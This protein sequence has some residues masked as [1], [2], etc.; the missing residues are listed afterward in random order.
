M[1]LVRTDDSHADGVY[2]TVFFVDGVAVKVFKRREDAAPDHVRNVFKSEVTAYCYSAT[3]ANIC[4]FTKHFIGV[5]E[6]CR[7]KDKDGL[8]ISQQY[9]LN[10]AYEM[11]RLIGEPIKIGDLDQE[12]SQ[13]I[14][15]L[16][17]Q[18]G[19]WYVRDCSVFLNL[20]GQLTN[21]IDFAM[22]EYLLEHA[23]L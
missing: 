3:I 23:S 12:F 8:D 22:Q 11:K 15:G 13:Y 2:A 5:T 17:Q 21:V 16:F 7:I 18:A 1:K 14:Q 19:I 20:D 10:Y 6:V 4:K 9:Y